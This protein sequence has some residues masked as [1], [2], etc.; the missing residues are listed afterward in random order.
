[1]TRQHRISGQRSW[2]AAQGVLRRRISLRSETSIQNSYCRSTVYRAANYPQFE[3]STCCSVSCWSILERTF[4]IYTFVGR[5]SRRRSAKVSAGMD[6][7]LAYGSCCGS[8][9]VSASSGAPPGWRACAAP[10]LHR[11]VSR[12]RAR[13][14]AGGQRMDTRARVPRI[15]DTSASDRR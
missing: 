7:G 15:S 14:C 8:S 2:M 11:T 1:M 6:F 13:R 10:G 12:D 9:S 4:G 5:C 3:C